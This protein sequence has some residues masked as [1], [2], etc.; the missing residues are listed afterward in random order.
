MD[1]AEDPFAALVIEDNDEAS[2]DRQTRARKVAAPTSYRPKVVESLVGSCNAD[3][4]AL[5]IEKGADTHL[6]YVMER[7]PR[8]TPSAATVSAG[9]THGGYATFDDAK[10]AMDATYAQQ[11]YALCLRIALNVLAGGIRHRS[12]L[13]EVL[14]HAV[15]C[16]LRLDDQT[17]FNALLARPVCK[18][19]LR[20]RMFNAQLTS[21]PATFSHAL[22]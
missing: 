1:L 20:P 19:G 5:S 12:N 9:D 7:R 3:D 15:R 10:A 16:T 11:N 8:Q 22:L 18:R 6:L 14:D 4:V 17:T 13:L 2:S 21:L